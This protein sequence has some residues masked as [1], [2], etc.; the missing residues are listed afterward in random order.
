MK[1]NF[2]EYFY[3]HK[4]SAYGI[5]NGRL[6][7]MTLSKAFN[8]VLNNTVIGCFDDWEWQNGIVDNSDEIR[9][10]SDEMMDL[11]D[12]VDDLAEAGDREQVEKIVNRIKEIESR[13]DELE[14]EENRPTEIFQYYIVSDGG[15]NIIKEFTHDP[16]LYSETADMY[17]WGITHYGTSWDYVLTDVELASE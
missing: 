3:G 16:L 8:N 15:A 5:E 14:D 2:T 10:L 12:Q 4:I 13:L 17:L 9:E 6:D 11:E 1:S 7:Y